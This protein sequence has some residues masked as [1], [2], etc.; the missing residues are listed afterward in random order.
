MNGPRG[1]APPRAEVQSTQASLTRWTH[2]KPAAL[3]PARWASGA[4]R[5][6]DVAPPAAQVA[7]ARSLVAVELVVARVV[8]IVD[9]RA[10][11]VGLGPL[12][13]AVDRPTEVLRGLLQPTGQAQPTIRTCPLAAGKQCAGV[14]QKRTKL[15]LVHADPLGGAFAGVTPR[16]MLRGLRQPHGSLAKA[17]P[18]QATPA[19]ARE[20]PHLEAVA[21][22]VR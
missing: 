20:H 21:A 17:C 7:Q 8:V 10:G 6:L 5:P 12:P 11:I 1:V 22:R 4:G 19:R 2:S 3:A 14:V 9:V 16:A 15:A 13:Q 18:R